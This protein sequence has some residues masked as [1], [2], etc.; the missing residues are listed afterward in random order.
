MKLNLSRDKITRVMARKSLTTT[1][2]GELMGVT[3]AYASIMVNKSS[4]TP[5]AVGRLANALGVD[6]TEILED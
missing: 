4:A 6:V 2:V 3:R 1:K 5:K